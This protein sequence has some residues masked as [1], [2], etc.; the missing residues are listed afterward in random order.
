M[1]HEIQTRKDLATAYRIMA[2]LGW[3]DLTA[4]HATA[5]IPDTEYILINPWGYAF[6]E[7]T[8][9]NLIRITLDE[10]ITQRQDINPAGILIHSAIHKH[11]GTGAVIHTHSVAGAAVAADSRGLLPISQIS[12]FARANLAYHEYDG[13]FVDSDEQQSLIQDLGNKCMM[14]MRNHGLLTTGPDIKVALMRMNTLQTACEIQ[15]LCNHQHV[16]LIS[17]AAQS[18]HAHRVQTLNT[19]V[20]WSATWRMLSRMVE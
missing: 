11:T 3:S 14:I 6:S 2:K 9:D 8:P 7:I 18:S 19:L 10:D 17:D 13:I 12:L 4:G 16:Q 15:S 1:T 5:R 20:D